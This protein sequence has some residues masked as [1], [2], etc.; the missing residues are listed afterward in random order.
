LIICIL[1]LC[2]LYGAIL[3]KIDQAIEDLSQNE[4]FDLWFWPLTLGLRSHIF[5][6]VFRFLLLLYGAILSK[7][8]QVA[9]RSGFIAKWN[10]WTSSLT[11]D[12]GIKVTFFYLHLYGYYTV[13]FLAKSI[14]PFR[15]YR[16]IKHLSFDFD[17]WSWVKV[18]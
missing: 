17:L 2:L 5:V 3:S 10:I 13:Q 6:F 12:L 8:D 15:I 16:K 11:I 14:K 1:W 9:S 7:I 4:I 18:T